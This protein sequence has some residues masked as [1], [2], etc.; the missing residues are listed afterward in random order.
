MVILAL[1]YHGYNDSSFILHK[2]TASC[3]WCY[4]NLGNITELGETPRPIFRPIFYG[5][6]PLSRQTK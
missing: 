2:K 1:H 3:G 6:Y 4:Y 5:I